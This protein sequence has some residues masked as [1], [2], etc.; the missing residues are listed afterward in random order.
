MSEIR[1]LQ[2]TRQRA[3][4]SGLR[5]G[6]I[7]PTDIDG[8]IEF[9][10]RCCIFMETKHGDADLPTGQRLWLERNCD[11]WG[12]G[13]IVLVVRKT[14]GNNSLTYPIGELPV[15][16]YRRLGKWQTPP[17]QSL[18]CVRWIERFATLILGREVKADAPKSHESVSKAPRN[19]DAVTAIEVP[20]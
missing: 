4:F 11:R 2:H 15:V 9:E 17:N 7:R 16:E 6:T 10:G 12:D 19:F 20:F 18:P 8:S 5:F 1:N 13:G 14:N 3:D